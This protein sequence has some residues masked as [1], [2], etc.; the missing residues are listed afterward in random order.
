MV[1]ASYKTTNMNGVQPIDKDRFV[2]AKLRCIN[3]HLMDLKASTGVVVSCDS[4]LT[5]YK[6]D[7]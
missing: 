2:C 5:T 7:W 6:S 1:L 4:K 3:C